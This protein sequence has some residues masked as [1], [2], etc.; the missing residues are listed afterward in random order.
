MVRTVLSVVAGIVAW[1]ALVIA[2]DFVMSKFWPE[3]EAAKPLYAFTL[4]MMIARLT[5]STIALVAA[6][7]VTARI[8]PLSR[9]APWALG[10]VMFAVFAPYH[11]TI[12]A[13]FPVWY[14]AYFL[15][16]LVAIPAIVGSVGGRKPSV[17][18]R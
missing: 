16:S 14:H 3:Y 5:E 12:W 7:I 2:I 9:Y 10:I 13:K 15:T 6:A 4:P 8:A 18:S 11:Y 1:V 17:A